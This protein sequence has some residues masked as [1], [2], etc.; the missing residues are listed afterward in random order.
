MT[1]TQNAEN[2]EF[3]IHYG[4][5]GTHN[6]ADRGRMVVDVSNPLWL[7]GDPSHRQSAR[8]LSEFLI[9][10]GWRGTCGRCIRMMRS[11]RVS[12]PLRLEGDLTQDVNQVSQYLKF[13]IHYGWRGTISILK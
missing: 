4:W 1:N 5:R 11:Y 3:L 8:R 13:L 2:F 12:N 9:H 7:E 6:R 10:Y